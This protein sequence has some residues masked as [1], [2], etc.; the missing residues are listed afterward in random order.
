[1]ITWGEN[2]EPTTTT[3]ATIQQEVDQTNDYPES[4]KQTLV[5]EVEALMV[6][7]SIMDHGYKPSNASW[8]VDLDLPRVQ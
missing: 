2:D 7:T 5:L 4:T 1:M 8:I 6:N 3:M